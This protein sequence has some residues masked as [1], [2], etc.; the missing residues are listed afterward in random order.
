MQSICISECK[1]LSYAWK[2]SWLIKWNQSCSHDICF[3]LF[4]TRENKT[5]TEYSE[6]EVEVKMKTMFSLKLGLLE[7]YEKVLNIFLIWI[8]LKER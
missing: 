6:S 1:K 5:K 8:I 3:F 4:Y 2:L 7:W